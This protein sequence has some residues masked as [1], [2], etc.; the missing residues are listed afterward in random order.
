[1]ECSVTMDNENRM[2]HNHLFHA[3]MLKQH[4]M[5]RRKNINTP[6]NPFKGASSCPVCDTC[7]QQKFYC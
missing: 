2:K 7:C 6:K 5:A 3:Q 4:K 1:M